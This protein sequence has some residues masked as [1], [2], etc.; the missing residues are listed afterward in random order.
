[1]VS[2]QQKQNIVAKWQKFVEEN[3]EIEEKEKKKLNHCVPINVFFS[4][5]VM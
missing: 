4:N 1:V 2:F 3:K 5:F